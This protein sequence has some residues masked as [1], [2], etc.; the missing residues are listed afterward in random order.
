MSKKY[1]TEVVRRIYEN[2]EGVHIEV[3]PDSDGLEC[4]VLRTVDEDSK[5]YYGEI[6]LMLPKELARLVGQALID[7]SNDVRV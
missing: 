2:D 6:N 7:S 3:A 4:V 1:Q 5:N